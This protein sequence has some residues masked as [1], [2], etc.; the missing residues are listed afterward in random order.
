MYNTHLLK[1][2]TMPHINLKLDEDQLT[3]ADYLCRQRGQ[4]RTAYIREAIQEYNVQI[5]RELLARKFRE[6][7]E[8]CREENLKIGREMEAAEPDLEER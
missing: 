8:K 6:A 4:T 3:Q 7:S 1:K 2:K 5:E